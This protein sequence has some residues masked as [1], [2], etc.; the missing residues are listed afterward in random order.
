[1]PELF[2]FGCWTAGS[3]IGNE[4]VLWYQLVSGQ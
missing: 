3:W 4:V 2:L 1:M